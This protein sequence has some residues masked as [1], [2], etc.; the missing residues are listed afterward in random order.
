MI[1]WKVLNCCGGQKKQMMCGSG[2]FGKLC[3]DRLGMFDCYRLVL[4]FAL[5]WLWRGV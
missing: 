2:G 5:I 3:V 1:R 4:S